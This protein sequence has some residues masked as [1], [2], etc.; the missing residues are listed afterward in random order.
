MTGG[1]Y[2]PDTDGALLAMVNVYKT[3]PVRKSFFSGDDLRVGAVEGVSL[4]VPPGRTL[5]LVG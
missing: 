4:S 1:I 3:F 2:R 5:G